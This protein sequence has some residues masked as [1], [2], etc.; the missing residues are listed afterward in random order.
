MGQVLIQIYHLADQRITQGDCIFDCCNFRNYRLNHNFP[1]NK[2]IFPSL[3]KI[4]PILEISPLTRAFLSADVKPNWA[5]RKKNEIDAESIFN[6]NKTDKTEKEDTNKV[7]GLSKKAQSVL[8]IFS[9]FF[10]L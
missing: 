3:S 7:T 4:T 1:A 5:F 2:V 9:C 8:V 6:Q 10:R